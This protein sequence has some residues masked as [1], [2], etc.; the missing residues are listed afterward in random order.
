MK[1]LISLVL[2]LALVLASCAVAFA[3][4]SYKI[5]V[6]NTNT[7][8]TID[9]KTFKAY[10]IFDATYQT[11]DGKQYVAYFINSDNY[12]YKNA[13]AKAELDK[14][15][16]FEAN[17]ADP[18]L[19]NVK[20]KNGTELTSAQAYA[21]SSALTG[22]VP[23]E[24]DAS[25]VGSGNTAVIDVTSKGAGYYLV[26]G[27]VKSTDTSVTTTV[28][29]AVALVN[30]LDDKATIKAKADLPPLDK[31]AI[32]A[33]VGE[34]IDDDGKIAEAQVGTT[35]THELHSTVPD[36]TGFDEYRYRFHDTMGEGLTYNKDAKVF[37][38]NDVA[39][40][41]ELSS[42][43]FTLV[44]NT[45]AGFVLDIPFATLQTLQNKVGEKVTVRYTVTINDTA[46]TYDYAKN[47]AYLEYGHRYGDEPYNHTPED[48]TYE[49]DINVDVNKY[50]QEGENKVKL[51]NAEFMLFKGGKDADQTKDI[52]YK[53]DDTN[54]KVTWVAKANGDKIL[55]DAN[56]KLAE[57]FKGL[58]AGTYCLLETK[59]PDGFNA[60][61]EPVE[62][63]LTV[64]QDANNKKKVTITASQG[65][66]TG[67]AI[68]LSTA[69][70]AQPV[71]AIDVE[72]NHGT[73]L[74]ST[75]GIGTTIF[76]ILGGLLV[77][78]AGVILVARRKAH[79]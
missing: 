31:E 4:D 6:N 64:T 39:T 27:E 13:T 53:W 14:Y 30:V 71:V 61:K 19:I 51:A 47:T 7:N 49:I 17:T 11:I 40:A 1:K 42:S 62:F 28:P 16:T 76:Y 20:I 68:D 22:L 29:T 57:Q 70:G 36:I 37:I 78:G 56:G 74:P 48:E 67:G 33:E 32:E 79:D 38:G 60:L 15:F 2:A 63:T 77:I 65:T 8:V 59:A 26:T 34:I 72:N 66:V 45:A 55:T 43:Q 18:T 25:G 73:E 52:F 46:L 23:T 41:V 9:G 58:A 54:K 24:A 75:G 50:T 12:Y 5:T 10:K 35:I 44:E 69:H 3:A 21:L